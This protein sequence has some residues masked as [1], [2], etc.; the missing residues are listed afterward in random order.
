MTT[1]TTTQL[2]KGFGE[3]R[4]QVK[5]RVFSKLLN[6]SE[7]NW[8]EIQI[9]TCSD[10]GKEFVS[11]SSKITESNPVEMFFELENVPAL[12]ATLQTALNTANQNNVE[13][14]IKWELNE[15]NNN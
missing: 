14:Q 9:N 8:K 6:M 1:N 10:E 7:F 11:I 15:Q 4:K 5:A 13:N 3:N 12:I 2:R